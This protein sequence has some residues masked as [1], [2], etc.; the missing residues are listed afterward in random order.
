[1]KSL[2]HEHLCRFFDSFETSSKF[3]I[4]LEL[5]KGGTLL[6]RIQ[7][8]GHFDEADASRCI[9]TIANAVLFLHDHGVC[10]RDIKPQNLLFKDQSPTSP[11]ILVDF[12]VA[13]VSN[14]NALQAQG[15]TIIA[16]MPFFLAPEIAQ[17]AAAGGRERRG[18]FSIREATEAHK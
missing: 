3:Y 1:M 17:S 8:I 2:R 10:H 18:Y 15:M 7:T 14:S 13:G 16:S 12:G 4:A 6:E 11:L 9:A 5:C